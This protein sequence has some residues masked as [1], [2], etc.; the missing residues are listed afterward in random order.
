[1]KPGDSYKCAECGGVFETSWS[2]QN[3]EAEASADGLT[4]EF[5]EADGGTEIVCDDCYKEMTAWQTT[6]AYVAGRL[7]R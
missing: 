7:G 1:M 6:A 2:D 3:A 4:P 5:R